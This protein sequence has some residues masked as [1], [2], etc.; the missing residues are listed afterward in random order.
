[1]LGKFA[2]FTREMSNCRTRVSF[3]SWEN[4]WCWEKKRGK[5]WQLS[6]SCFC[7]LSQTAEALIGTAEQELYLSSLSPSIPRFRIS[8]SHLSPPLS[9]SISLSFIHPLQFISLLFT[10]LSIYPLH[11]LF[12]YFNGAMGAMAPKWESKRDWF[13]SCLLIFR[14]LY[15]INI[16]WYIFITNGSLNFRLHS[17]LRVMTFHGYV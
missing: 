7:S 11:L 3:G 4:L 16:C 12:P 14:W 2:I 6:N 5:S 9:L 15:K 17:R 13:I 1:M 10:Y 8:C